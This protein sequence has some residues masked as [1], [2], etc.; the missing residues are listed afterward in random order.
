MGYEDYN[1]PTESQMMMDEQ[2]PTEEGGMSVNPATDTAPVQ[3]FNNPFGTWSDGSSTGIPD[4]FTSGFKVAGSSDTAEAEQTSPLKAATSWLGDFFKTTTDTSGR[5]QQSLAASIILGAAGSVM[6]SMS[7]DKKI[8]AER[9]L[10]S[11]KSSN[12]IREKT[13]EENRIR[14]AASAMPTQA[15]RGTRTVARPGGILSQAR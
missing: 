6:A 12:K 4:D 5:Q 9:D 1:V 14:A 2:W 15:N 3:S 8:R 7:Q 10:E 11:Q 13:E